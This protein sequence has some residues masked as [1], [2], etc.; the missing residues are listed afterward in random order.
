MKHVTVKPDVSMVYWT[1]TE[2]MPRLWEHMDRGNSSRREALDVSDK[3]LTI[4]K[5]EKYMDL[6]RIEK[7]EDRER[8]IGNQK[9]ELKA[10]LEA[11]GVT[12]EDLRIE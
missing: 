8:E 2:T 9:R 6:L 12:V 10:E 5:I 1:R 3:E 11:M 4:Y 7:A